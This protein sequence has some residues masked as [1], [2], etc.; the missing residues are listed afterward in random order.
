MTMEDVERA[1]KRYKELIPNVGVFAF[2]ASR[3][4]IKA[5][6]LKDGQVIKVDGS[7]VMMVAR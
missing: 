7:D 5:L 3:K 4:Q 2:N 1:V 6:G